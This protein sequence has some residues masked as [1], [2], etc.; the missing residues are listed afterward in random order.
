MLENHT[1]TKWQIYWKEQVANWYG[2]FLHEAQYLSLIH[3]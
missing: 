1:Q 3:I 2:M